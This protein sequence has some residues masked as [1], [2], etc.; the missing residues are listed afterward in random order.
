MKTGYIRIIN[1]RVYFEY[2]E[3]GKRLVE[4][5]NVTTVYEWYDEITNPNDDKIYG[6]GFSLPEPDKSGNT[7]RMIKDGQSC[8]AEVN[9]KAKIIELL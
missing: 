4:V 3:S 5:N 9:G 1:G 8:K 2:Y 6:Y 7:A